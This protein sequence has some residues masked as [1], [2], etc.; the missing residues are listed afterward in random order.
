MSHVDVVIQCD[1]TGSIHQ[2]ATTQFSIFGAGHKTMLQGLG[3]RLHHF[4]FLILAVTVGATA[5]Y[6][7]D[8]EVRATDLHL[9]CCFSS[10]Y[11]Y[12]SF[13]T[14]LGLIIGGS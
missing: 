14:S 8:D 1:L 5:E 4:R 9:Q 12:S 2:T 10:L 3:T 11:R 13:L 6:K 7:R